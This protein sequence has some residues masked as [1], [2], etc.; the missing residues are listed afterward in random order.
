MRPR[1]APTALLAAGCAL[2]ACSGG[3]APGATPKTALPPTTAPNNSTNSTATSVTGAPPGGC[4]NLAVIAK[5]SLSRRAAQLVVVPALN[6]DMNG[7][8][9]SFAAG[10]GGVLILGQPV[11]GDLAQQVAAANRSAAPGV[12]L[13]VMSDEEGGGVQDRKSVV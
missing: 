2:A 1:R 4:A 13:A 8:G 3:R 5:W 9:A 11:P 7:L 10:A 12:P 6:A